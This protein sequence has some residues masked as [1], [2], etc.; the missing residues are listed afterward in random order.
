MRILVVSFRF[1]PSNS[2]G[3]LRV[4]K[5]AINLESL[6]EDVRVL[7]ALEPPLSND[8]ELGFDE[9]KVIRTRWRNINWI[10]ERLSGGS[11]KVRS[12]GYSRHTSARR[13]A[14][15]L[16]RNVVNFP[17]LAAGWIPYAIRTG[18]TAAESWKPDIILGSFGPQSSLIVASTIS[19]QT[20]VP[21]VAEF[22]DLWRGNPY[23][24]AFRWRQ[25]VDWSLERRIVASASA[26]VTVSEPLAE[27]LH[28][29]HGKPCHVIRNGFDEE[30]LPEPT[31]PDPGPLTI[32][33]LGTIYPGQRDPS[34]L[35][36]VLR[37]DEYL[38]DRVRVEFYGRNLGD[39]DELVRE[40][41]VGRC[42]TV[43]SQVTR[44]ESLRLQVTSDALLLL[45]SGSAR[46]AGTLPGKLFEYAGCARPVL[47][48]G[49][50]GGLS[51][52]MIRNDAL[53]WAP[54]SDAEL[55][56]LLV[57][58]VSQKEH[59]RIPS[60]T[61]LARSK[62][63]RRHQTEQLQRILHTVAAPASAASAAADGGERDA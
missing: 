55:H 53:G 57:R 44:Q 28:A 16:W 60:T 15:V 50:S 43:G 10:P 47:Q 11:E 49:G 29:L 19:R 4:G 6:G 36:R 24:Q 56:D 18:V 25:K 39:L 38:S 23:N 12:E 54:S 9:S 52:Q 34:P 2:S 26:I 32:R 33:H 63:S 3:S 22:R 20:G 5:N 21:W 17:D 1:P 48:I 45:M 35:F 14:E 31:E 30:D 59:A 27:E 37:D 51:A 13:R 40:H 7:T 58:L 8:L 61:T 62:L 46:D 41:R 42:V